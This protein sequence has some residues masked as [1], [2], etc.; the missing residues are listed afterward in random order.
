MQ[1]TPPRVPGRAD[2][3]GADHASALDDRPVA[4]AD[5]VC[6]SKA[7]DDLLVGVAARAAQMHADAQALITAGVARISNQQP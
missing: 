1:P 2:L 4:P 5:L 3:P 7:D 6:R